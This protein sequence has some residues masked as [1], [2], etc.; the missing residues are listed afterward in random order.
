MEIVHKWLIGDAPWRF[1]FEVLL[2]FVI[3]YLALLVVL[4]LMGRRFAGQLS[5]VELAIMVMLGAAIGPPL[6]TPEKGILPTVV[7][8]ITLFACFRLL[9]WLTFRSHKM[10][11]LSQGDA[12]MLVQDGRLAQ[13]HLRHAELSRARIFSE[14]R[15]LD[16][17]HLGELRRAWLEPSGRVSLL[18]YREPRAG[19][20]IL[21]AQSE[22]FER[23]I[24]VDDGYACGNCGYVIEQQSPPVQGCRYCQHTRWERAVKRLGTEKLYPHRARESQSDDSAA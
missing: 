21:P 20:W 14:L 12:T 18:R 10:E 13:S 5:I 11:M 17:Q 23:R 2:R 16:V 7:L 4:R 15:A 24:L 3:I 22:S 8:L 1:A 6:Q 9:S 19:L